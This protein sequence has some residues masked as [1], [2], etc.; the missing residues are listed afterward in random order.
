MSE[1]N[2]AGSATGEHTFEVTFR[3]PGVE[4]YVFTFG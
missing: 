2:T 3:D 1:A 4:V